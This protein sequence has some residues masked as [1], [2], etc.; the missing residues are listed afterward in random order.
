MVKAKKLPIIKDWT[1]SADHITINPGT[2][3]DESLLGKQVELKVLQYAFDDKIAAVSIVVIVNGEEIEFSKEK[4]HITL[5]YDESQGARP[6]MSNNLTNWKPVPKS[7]VL[8][9]TI[10]ES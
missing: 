2:A 4:P 9:G 6:V 5:A 10:M 3:Q 7:F 8:S 1:E